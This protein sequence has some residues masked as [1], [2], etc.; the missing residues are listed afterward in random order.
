MQIQQNKYLG[1]V[2]TIMRLLAQKDGDSSS[3]SN[4]IDE[5]EAGNTNTSLKHIVFDSQNK[6]DKKEE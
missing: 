4:Q 5:R 1:H 3:Y 6:D 2:L